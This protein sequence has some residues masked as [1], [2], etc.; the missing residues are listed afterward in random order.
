MAD[1]KFITVSPEIYGKINE[2]AN[3]R[4]ITHGDVIKLLFEETGHY[5][6]PSERE[7]RRY[8]VPIG[9]VL[10]RYK[11]MSPYG[12]VS[13]IRQGK[14]DGQ[15]KRGKW[16]VDLNSLDRYLASRVR[17]GGKTYQEIRQGANPP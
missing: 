12:L 13:W 14:V 1:R 7:S 8:W 2:I 4:G 3:E 11:G 6:V 15:Q 16:L 17:H 5:L 9:E 10:G